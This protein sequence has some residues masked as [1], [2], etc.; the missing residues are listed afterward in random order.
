M[1][2]IV[3]NGGAPLHGEVELSGFK[4]AALPIIYACVLVRDKCVIENVPN[5]LDIN[6]S[7]EILRGMGAVIRTIDKND[8]GDSRNGDFRHIIHMQDLTSYIFVYK[9]NCI[10][11]RVSS[12]QCKAQK[13]HSALRVILQRSVFVL[14]KLFQP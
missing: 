2:K 7:F 4:N 10:I 8:H 5:V 6:R 1:E 12:S 11:I 14:N 13:F 3:I 9:G